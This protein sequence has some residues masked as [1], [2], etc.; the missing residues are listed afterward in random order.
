MLG[1]VIIPHCLPMDRQ[2]QERVGQWWDMV[3]I[4]VSTC[5]KPGLLNRGG[6]WMGWPYNRGGSWMGGLIIGVTVGWGGLIRRGLL[7]TGY[8]NC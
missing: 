5:L 1:K 3:S 7:Y 6:C 2:D 8:E 4:K